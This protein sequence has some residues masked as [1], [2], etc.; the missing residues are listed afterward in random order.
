M[1]TIYKLA[2]HDVPFMQEKSEKHCPD[3]EPVAGRTGI[4]TQVGLTPEVRSFESS[5]TAFPK[6]TDFYFT[7]FL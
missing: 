1:S 5:H 4:R 6:T 7:A 3:S 2:L